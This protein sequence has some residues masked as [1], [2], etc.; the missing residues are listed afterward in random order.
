MALLRDSY[1]GRQKGFGKS[2]SIFFLPGIILGMGWPQRSQSSKAC[3]EQVLQGQPGVPA[4][5][6][7]PK[8]RPLLEGTRSHAQPRRARALAF[9]HSYQPSATSAVSRLPQLLGKF[10]GKEAFAL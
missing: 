6:P 7:L 8:A 9:S 4:L 5:R 3:K 1:E 2:H 10:K